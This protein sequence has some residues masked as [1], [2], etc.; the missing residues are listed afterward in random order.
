[1][2]N[3][4]RES[5]GKSFYL[6]GFFTF[7]SMAVHMCIFGILDPCR[8]DSKVSELCWSICTF[9][10]PFWVSITTNWPALQDSMLVAYYSPVRT[11]LVLLVGG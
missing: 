11:I 7:L 10:Y 6:I 3:M 2:D 5:V 8:C 4:L 9:I 1:M